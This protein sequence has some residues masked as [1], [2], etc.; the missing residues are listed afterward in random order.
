[1]TKQHLK[2]REQSLSRCAD[3]QRLL[4]TLK[5]RGPQPWVKPSHERKKGTDVNHVTR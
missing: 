1:M 4:Q 2:P 3:Y 5:K